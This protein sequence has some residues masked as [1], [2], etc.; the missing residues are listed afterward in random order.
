MKEDFIKYPKYRAA[1]VR[2]FDKMCKARDEAGLVNNG[3]WRDGEHVMRWW[4]GEDPNQI[5]L[6]DYMEEAGIEFEQ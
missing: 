3:A 1:Y 5:T 6:F 2:A 4:V